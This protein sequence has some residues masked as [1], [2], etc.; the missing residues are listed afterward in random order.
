MRCMESMGHVYETGRSSVAPQL[1]A[2][3]TQG[4][5]S[6]EIQRLQT[7][8]EPEDDEPTKTWS[9]PCHLLDIAPA[10]SRTGTFKSDDEHKS[11]IGTTQAQS[12]TGAVAQPPGAVA[13][14]QAER[15]QAGNLCI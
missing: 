3:E 4:W 14:W 13:H 9:Q 5:K 1:S 12:R 11:G 2:F 7:Q 15:N 8:E 10:Q 6:A